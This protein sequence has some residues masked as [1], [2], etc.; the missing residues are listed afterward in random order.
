MSGGYM[1][2]DKQSPVPVYYQLKKLILAKIAAGEFG[3]N[4]PIPSERELC[5]TLKISRMTVR[6]ALNQLA[7]EGVLYREKGRGTFVSKSKIEQRNIMSFSDMVIQK[8]MRPAAKILYFQ[9]TP[10]TP[11]FPELAEPLNSELFYH[12]RRLRLADT[13]PI[14]IEE[15]FIPEK[16]CPNLEQFDL[17]ASLYRIIREKYTLSIS[18]VDN[19][20]ESSLPHQDERELLAIPDNTPVIRIN[21]KS[22]TESDLT[23]L[24]ERSIYRADE[25]KFSA[26]IYLR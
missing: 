17:T 15:V 19:E 23:I 21:G 26:R 7:N 1:F 18:Y 6:Q 4:Q 20:I 10:P 22:Y 8:G 12:I 14:G 11:D 16:H 25:Y 2:V 9:K 13:T 24:Y 3:P 5:D